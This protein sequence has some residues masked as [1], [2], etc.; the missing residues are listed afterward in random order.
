MDK[1]TKAI[2][3]IIVSS[4]GFA[5]M[6]AF[7]KL[8]GSL[9]AFQKSFFRNLVSCIVAL[10][11]ILKHKSSFFGKKENQKYLLARSILGT[12]GIIANFYAIDHLVLADS[13][14]LNKLSPFFLTIFAVLFLKEK[15][16]PMQIG[17]LFLAFFGSLFI[18]KPSFNLN[19]IPALI[20]VSSA[21]F[22][23]AAYTFVRFLGGKEE[24]YTIVFYFSFVSLVVTFP[25]MIMDFVPMTFTQ[26]SYLL[27]AGGAASIGQ[28]ALTLAYKNAPASEI[29]IFDYV[30]IIF[31]ALIGL[32]IW[33]EIPDIYSLLGYFIIIGA[34][35]FVFIYNKR[36]V[37]TIN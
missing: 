35:I 6:G 25:V 12:L 31:S 37:K 18:I 14:M 20:G 11:L 33:N 2:L 4:L 13:A 32:F 22:A 27:L 28:F 8:S 29:S 19:I 9:P 1:K 24:Y 36:K 15:I 34:S 21:I 30:N 16:T 3:L 5:V 26:V 7:V 23:G 17:A 10:G